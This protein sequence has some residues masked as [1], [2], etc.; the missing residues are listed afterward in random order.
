M[1]FGK[2]R[3]MGVHKVLFELLVSLTK[4][5]N[6]VMVRKFEVMMGQELNHSV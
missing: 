5:L 1:E 2:S 4:L 6:M 3:I